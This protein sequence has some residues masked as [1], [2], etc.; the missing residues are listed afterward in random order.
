MADAR[1]LAFASFA[2]PAKGVLVL[3]CEEGL[4]FGPATRKALAPTGDLVER[5]AAAERFT[6]KSG[7]SLDIVAPAGLPVARLAILG[8]GKAASSRR[9]IS[10]SSA[11]AAM[12]KVPSRG[13]RGR[14]SSRNL[15]AARSSRTRR[16]SSRSAPSCAPMCSTA[17]RPSAEEG[18]EAPGEAADHDRGEQRGG[19][20]RRPG[21]AEQRAGRR[22][23]GD[24]ARPDQRA[25]QRALPGG[26]RPPTLDAQEARRRGRGA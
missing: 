21:R 4:K 25:R 6:G 17:T 13:R 16:P 23:R 24:G 19:G 18:E 22:W 14:R 7:S 3:F 5:A 11:A 12:G 2:T 1:K 20:A 15:P 10:S 8:V 26:V 9:R